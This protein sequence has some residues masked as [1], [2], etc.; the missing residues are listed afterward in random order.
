[1]FSLRKLTKSSRFT[2]NRG[3][4][5]AH[6]DY[7]ADKLQPGASAL[8]PEHLNPAHNEDL[9]DPAP[10]AGEYLDPR[11]HM[12][13]TFTASKGNLLAWG[14]ILRRIS[15]NQ[16]YDLASNV[17]TF[18]SS[19]GAMHARLDIKGETYFSGS[20]V[21]EIHLGDRALAAYAGQFRSTELETVCSL[22][23]EKGDLIL[24]NHNNPLQKLT[25]IAK[26]EFDA[27]DFGRLV[28]ERDSGGRVVGFRV[29]TQEAR[30]I[31]FK[32]ED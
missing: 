27:G 3:R 29:F 14:A 6:S 23:L 9:P 32:K 18:E 20:R 12:V 13:Y 15:A 30:G 22:S 17:F 28:F 8:K 2:T 7:L 21:Q 25:P 11:T 4:R 1:M 31:S 24:H 26:D 10:F 16:F 5:G 19:E